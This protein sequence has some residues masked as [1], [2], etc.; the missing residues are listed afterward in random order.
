MQ[1]G[2]FQFSAWFGKFTA[3]LKFSLK[4][5]WNEVFLQKLEIRSGLIFFVFLGFIFFYTENTFKHLKSFTKMIDDKK[6]RK[7]KQL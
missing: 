1:L 7:W 2:I 6:S 3:K 4:E 5:K